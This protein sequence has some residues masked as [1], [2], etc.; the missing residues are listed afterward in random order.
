MQRFFED[1]LDHLETLHGELHKALAATPEE[2]LDWSPAPDVNSI[3]VLVAH[4]AG[5]ERFWAADVIREQGTDRVR[6]QEFE[7]QGLTAAELAQG[8][9]DAL[10]AVREAVAGLDESDLTR[11]VTEPV[12]GREFTIGWCLLHALEHTAV[13]TGHAQLMVQTS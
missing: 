4:V 5:A 10:A 9:D 6:Q 12:R 7:T 3:A 8:L 2:R 1:Y 11:V 13:H